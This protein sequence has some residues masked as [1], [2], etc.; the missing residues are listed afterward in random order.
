M[1]VLSI[2]RPGMFTTVQDVGRWGFQ[3]RGVP[4][5]GAMDWYSHRRANRIVGNADTAAT[6]EATLIG[7]EI[8]FERETRFAVTGAMFALSLMGN[9]SG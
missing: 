3:A 8:A 6:L 4:V 7:P 5:S 9:P 1:S 2:R